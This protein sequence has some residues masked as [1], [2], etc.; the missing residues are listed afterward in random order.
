MPE[1][2]ASPT[3]DTSST[4]ST[5]T[6]S[7]VDTSTMTLDQARQTP[8]PVDTTSKWYQKLDSEFQVNPTVQKYK[9]ENEFVKAH[10]ELVKTLGNEKIALPKDANDKA[11]YDAIFEK[12]GAPKDETGYEFTKHELPKELG[13]QNLDGFKKFAKE[14]NLTKTQAAKLY[15]WHVGN[16]KE[17]Y[18]QIQKSQEEQVIN[19]TNELRREF[20]INFDNNLKAANAAATKLFGAEGVERLKNVVG[21]DVAFLK[22]MYEVSKMMGE[23][24]IG[25]FSN[26]GFTKTPAEAKIELDAIMANSNDPYW[27]NGDTPRTVQRERVQYVEGLYQMIAAGKK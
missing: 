16:V 4:T 17:Q 3:T 26:S 21:N 18:E 15:D 13:E 11:A 6:T 23:D 14:L 10:L 24:A 2:T 1:Q 19:A 20:G 5:A 9:N 8:A 25:K 7:T 27:G 22:G 12:L